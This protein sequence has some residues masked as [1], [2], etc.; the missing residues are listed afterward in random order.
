MV[1]AIKA[2][3]ALPFTIGPR[4]QKIKP[5]GS[6]EG[7]SPDH[8][9]NGMRSTMFDAIFIPAGSGQ[10][11]LAKDG[12]ARFW[13]REAFGH[14]KAIGSVG[15]GNEL[16]KAAISEVEGYQV[17]DA[18][19]HGVHNW[20]GVVTTGQTQAEGWGKVVE[21][22]KNVKDAKDFVQTFFSE[23]AQHRNWQRELDGLL[24]QVSC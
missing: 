21:L 18:K 1:T 15:E 13:V 3:G 12:L 2:A 9:F 22:V 6:G 4:R 7:V 23:I 24:M 17:A 14:C 20:Y 8:H 5:S 10:A 16:V 19:Q 11:S